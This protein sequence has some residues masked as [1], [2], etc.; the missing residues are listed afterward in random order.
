MYVL[1]SAGELRREL[2]ARNLARARDFPHEATYGKVP[3]VLYSPEEDGLGHGNFLAASYRRIRAD[4]G[5]Q[6]RL[7]KVY[8]ASERV[9]RRHDRWRSELDCANSSDALLMNLFCYPGVTNRPGVCRLLGLETGERPEF[10]V[11]VQV[12]LT[13]GRVNRTE[14]DMLLGDLLVEA[15]LTETGFQQARPA[16]VE[17]YRDFAEV[18]EAGELPRTQHGTVAPYAEYQLVRGVLA[19]HAR[20][21]RF[22]V[23][24]DGRRGDLIE[25][26]FRVMRAVRGWELRDRLQLLTWQELATELPEVV[27]V[28][29]AEKYGVVSAD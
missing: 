8:T 28:F 26:W 6:R 2:S 15:K 16:L 1:R 9:A 11:R 10:G 23:L 22:L 18:F 14:V 3:S 17:R 20:K 5:W 13:G 29:L 4:K 12:P 25:S 7:G 24:C 19:A 27:R 21:G